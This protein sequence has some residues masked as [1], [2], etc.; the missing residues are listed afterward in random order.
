[1]AIKS[2]GFSPGISASRV[3]QTLDLGEEQQPLIKF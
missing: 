3:L 1:L 2:N